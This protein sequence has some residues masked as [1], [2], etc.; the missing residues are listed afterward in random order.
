MAEALLAVAVQETH[1]EVSV[2]SAGLG[3]LVGKPAD[4][5]AKDL[6]QARNIDISA[7]RAR[8]TTPEIVFGSDLILTMS[9]E[10]SQ[11]LEQQYPGVRGRVHR[12][13]KWG[14]Y[15]ISDPFK[16]P[17]T[18]FEHALILIEQGIG[19]WYRKLWA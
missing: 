16:R 5:H 7:H 15:D 2:S 10:Q 9:T 1:P 11:Q 17:K 4:P 8:Q 13:G 3:A 19:E 18:A 12:I 6:M 14:E